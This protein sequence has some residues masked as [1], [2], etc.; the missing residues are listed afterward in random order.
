MKEEAYIFRSIGIFIGMNYVFV[1]LCACVSCEIFHKIK[2]IR[3]TS[4]PFPLLTLINIFDA[5]F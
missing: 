2:Q 1:K 5:V 3:T 4:P